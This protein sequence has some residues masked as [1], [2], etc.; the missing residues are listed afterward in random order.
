VSLDLS[1]QQYD[2]EFIHG[3]SLNIVTRKEIADRFQVHV[4]TVHGWTE[5]R[6]TNKFPRPIRTISRNSGQAGAPVEIYWWPLIHQ[7]HESYIPR[8]GPKL[9]GSRPTPSMGK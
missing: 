3:L 7:W 2:S 5:R 4:R 9:N 8:R 6:H 1:E